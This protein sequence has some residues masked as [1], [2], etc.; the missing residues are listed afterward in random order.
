MRFVKNLCWLEIRLLHRIY[1]NSMKH[2]VRQ[3]AHCILLSYQG[4]E[5]AELASILDKTE[6]TIYTWLNQWETHHFAGLYDKKG[7]GRKP[8]LHDGHMMFSSV[9]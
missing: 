6:R 1:K 9:R 2:H 7:R 5:V 4:T 8:K 3:R